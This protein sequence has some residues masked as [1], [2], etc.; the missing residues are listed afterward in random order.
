MARQ[1]AR[2]LEL[3][4]HKSSRRW[5]K[6]IKGKYQYFGYGK[7]VSDKKSYKIALAKFR[8]FQQEQEEAELDEKRGTVPTSL[9]GMSWSEVDA[10]YIPSICLL[11]WLQFLG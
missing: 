5:R 3:S 4:F 1:N 6:M 8:Q 10:G 7:G 11:R 9:G 2:G